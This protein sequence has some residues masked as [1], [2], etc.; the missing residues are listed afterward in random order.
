MSRIPSGTVT[1]LF[2]DIAGSTRLWETE[3][4]AMAAALRRH[5][6]ILRQAIEGSAGYVFKTVGDAF[7]AAF[8][9]PQ[10]AVSA[11]VRAQ[12]GLLEEP[13]PTTMPVRVRMGLHT[14]VCEERD[15]DYFGPT[16]NRAARLEAIAHGGQTVV[17]GTTAGLTGD[18]LADGV[19]LRDLGQHRLRDL[20]RP[21]HVFQI[22]AEGLPASFP[23]LTSLD[24]PEFPNNLPGLLS[25]F[26]GRSTEIVAVRSLLAQARLVTLTGAGGCGKTRLGLQAAA[27]LLDTAPDGVW[28]TELAP[29]TDGAEIPA[30]VSAALGLPSRDEASLLTALREQDALLLLD[31]C[32]HLIGAVARLCGRI[33]SQCRQVRIMA[34]SREPLG[35]GGERVYRVAS[36]SLP[37]SDDGD[38]APSEAVQLFMDRA[39]AQDPGFVLDEA[40]GPL[41]ASVCRRLDGIPLAIELAAARLSSMSLGQ[42]STRLDQRFRLLTGGSRNAMPR[43][44]TLQATVDWS[45]SLLS[46]P[47][48]AT[49]RRLSVF[50]GGFELEGAEAVCALPDADVF[51]VLDL[52]SSLVDKSLV[53]ADHAAGGSV[54]YRLLETIR[55]YCAQELLRAD[56]DDTVLQVR[57]RHARYFLELAETAKKDLDGPAQGRWL[58]R[59]DLEWDNLRAA[60]GY[61]TD[62]NQ[63]DCVLRLGAALERFALSQAHVEVLDWLRT[64]IERA[65][66]AP[67]A[68]RVMIEAMLTCAEL[69]QVL[70]VMSAAERAA[71][72]RYSERALTMARKL[73][74][75]EMEGWALAALASAAYFERD[76][77]RMELLARESMEIARRIDEPRLKGSLL[78]LLEFVPGATYADRRSACEQQVECFRQAGDHLSTANA[79]ARMF[80]LHLHAGQPSLGRPYLDEAIAMAED[81]G[82]PLLRYFL[83]ADL[84]IV[85][86]IRDN[87]AEAA[88][89]VRRNLLT[90][91]R[92]GGGI[93]VAM[94][95]FAAAS[96]TGML[97]SAQSD[98]LTAARL[99]GAADAGI[100]AGLAIGTI[101][102]SGLEERLR[103]S[104]QARL[105][106]VLGDA[107]FEAA[108][109]AGVQMTPPRAVELALGRAHPPPLG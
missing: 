50:A 32:E 29:L 78:N 16:V 93:E 105:R 42:V 70:L 60:F 49:L 20:G 106:K 8:E 90:A 19:R 89:L 85:L 51:E 97:G 46:E 17:S 88:P 77:A 58:R 62:E 34:T 96:C 2:S 54:R 26:I 27:E 101:G 92:L 63:N 61:L 64:G 1:L 84:A 94:A 9:A 72:G 107:A 67:E 103:A 30:A 23:P 25:V 31:N 69:I 95:L 14:G 40:A 71:A 36:L 38:A 35:I 100:N 3:P 15:N 10:G 57:A 109:H 79:L 91:H 12:L 108:Y 87:A 18:A 98:F 48:R 104:E 13:W 74:D 53:V 37:G 28:L 75:E 4:D 73:G 82:S 47:E 102:W 99:H 6:S 7:C 11:A 5:D 83:Y 86:L 65:G 43:Q 68:S 59:L 33:T 44:Q 24:N 45:F 56:G 22:E 52:V 21:E 39:R 41:V 66:P 76:L 55:Q 81:L 80:S